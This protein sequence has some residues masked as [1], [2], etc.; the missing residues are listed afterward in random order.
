MNARYSWRSF[1]H[2]MDVPRTS[3]VVRA[4]AVVGRKRREWLAIG[5][6]VGGASSRRIGQVGRR[7]ALAARGGRGKGGVRGRLTSP[8]PPSLG[9]AQR[10]TLDVGSWVVLSGLGF[11][12]Q[13]GGWP[14]WALMVGFGSYAIWVVLYAEIT[15]QAGRSGGFWQR[16]EVA[17]RAPPERRFSS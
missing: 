7:F 16:F 12:Y 1:A 11:G 10:R 9:P 14:V 17:R 15:V 6:T 5:A 3:Q 2:R 13:L 8:P 4:C